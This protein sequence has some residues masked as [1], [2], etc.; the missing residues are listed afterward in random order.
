MVSLLAL[1]RAFMSRNQTKVG[2][3]IIM[4]AY[5]L[6]IHQLLFFFLFY[7]L[8]KHSCVTKRGTFV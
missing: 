7:R 2:P 3:L 8:W 6:V 4:T 5:I 1:N